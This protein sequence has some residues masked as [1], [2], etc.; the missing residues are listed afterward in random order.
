ME[1]CRLAISDR[2]FSLDYHF[3]MKA[4]PEFVKH[5]LTIIHV[6]LTPIL[7]LWFGVGVPFRQIGNQLCQ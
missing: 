5:C 2:N 7:S 1:A 4:E 6:R 3:K